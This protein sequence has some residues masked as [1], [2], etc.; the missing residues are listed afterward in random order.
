[1]SVSEH[2]R[3]ESTLPPLL[4]ELAI[5][6]VA[7]CLDNEYEIHHHE[8]IARNLGASDAQLSDL[9]DWQ[10]SPIH[11]EVERAV[12]RFAWEAT[13]ARRVSDGAAAEVIRL[14]PP[15]QVIELV[16]TVGWYHLCHVVIDSLG[17]EIES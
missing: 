1:M 17:V 9:G 11:S 4:R 10:H 13:A 7:R 5:L 8:P 16:L 2:V 12:I 14:L 15:D 6:S 3:D